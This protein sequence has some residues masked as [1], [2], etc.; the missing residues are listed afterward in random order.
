MAL[1]DLVFG[2]GQ[3]EIGAI[4]LDCLLTESTSMD[5][6]VTDYAVEEGAPITD[7]IERQPE[8]LNISGTITAA[9]IVL[10]SAGGKSKL[11]AAKDQFRALH[12][13]SET[14]LV[15]T[16]MDMYESMAIQALSISRDNSGV[17]YN[18]E[19]TLKHIRTVTLQKADIPPE[20]V[21]QA[22]NDQGEPLGKGTGAQGKAGTTVDG[23]KVDTT[24]KPTSE[25]TSD[26]QKKLNALMGTVDETVQ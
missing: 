21:Q 2:T 24:T 19:A 20:Q 13:A 26:L 10:F 15:I 3:S 18:V 11:I 7:H 12:E 9:G 8:V 6:L 1:L 14:V 22:T 23:G 16:G 4:P 25:L 17:K 5:S